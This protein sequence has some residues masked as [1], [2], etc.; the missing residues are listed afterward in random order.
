MR[1]LKEERLL[2]CGNRKFSI[3]FILGFSLFYPRTIIGC[4][5]VI[6]RTRSKEEKEELET[7]FENSGYEV[8]RLN[9]TEWFQKEK[10]IYYTP[11]SL[12]PLEEIDDRDC[13][14]SFF[15]D[16]DLTKVKECIKFI[17]TVKKLSKEYGYR[18][19]W[20]IGGGNRCL[21]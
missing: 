4:N 13:H 16:I 11:F 20:E 8:E 5:P 6:I 1:L 7:L 9:T 14:N 18:T 19:L 21:I 15:L 12:E 2:V 3:F 10:R 17:E